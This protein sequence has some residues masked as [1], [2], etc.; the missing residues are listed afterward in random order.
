MQLFDESGGITK[1]PHLI[2][3]DEYNGAISPVSFVRCRALLA[4]LDLRVSP[5]SAV[6]LVS[7]D[8]EASVDS[9][10]SLA[11]L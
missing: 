6:S 8:R 11:H 1:V 2:H 4:F 10:A 9:P 3:G 7:L 5:D